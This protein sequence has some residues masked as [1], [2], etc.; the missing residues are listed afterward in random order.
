MDKKLDILVI[1]DD[2]ELQFMF[3]EFARLVNH[4]YF[5]ATSGKESINLV[6][7]NFYHLIFLDYNLEDMDGLEIY[8]IAKNKTKNSKFV[9]MSG[10]VDLV[11]NKFNNKGNIIDFLEKPFSF[12][13]FRDIISKIESDRDIQLFEM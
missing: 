8:N 13:M 6:E 9:I 2:S 12:E 3:S 5:S 7:D 1:E 4:N 11:K 10:S